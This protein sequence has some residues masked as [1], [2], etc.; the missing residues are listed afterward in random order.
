LPICNIP[1]WTVQL[2]YWVYDNVI[3]Q[4]TLNSAMNWMVSKGLI[5][6]N[7]MI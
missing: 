1:E 7:E 4:E 6:C 3:S 2:F 5:I